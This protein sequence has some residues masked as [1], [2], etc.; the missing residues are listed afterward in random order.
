VGAVDGASPGLGFVLGSGVGIWLLFWSS[1]VSE[2]RLPDGSGMADE[3][4]DGVDVTPTRLTE[5]AATMP[6][7]PA[8]A[9]LGRLLIRTVIVSR[10]WL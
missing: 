3:G 8:G 1:S 4:A 2:G 7:P 9:V 5:R 10:V 6:S